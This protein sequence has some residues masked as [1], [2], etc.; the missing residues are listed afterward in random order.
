[1]RILVLDHT[2]FG[3]RAPVRS[4][5]LDDVDILVSDQPIPEPYREQIPARVQVVIA[6]E[7]Q[8]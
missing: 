5:S 4:G 8:A 7:V 6:D 2:K 1:V 3:R